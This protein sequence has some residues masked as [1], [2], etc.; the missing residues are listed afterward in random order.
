MPIMG[1]NCEVRV[2]VSFVAPWLAAQF[3][4]AH[5]PL[6]APIARSGADRRALPA[7]TDPA[8]RRKFRLYAFQF[9][10]R[11]GER[12]ATRFVLRHCLHY[13]GRIKTST[14]RQK[15]LT[16]LTMREWWKVVN[17]CNLAIILAA[18]IVQ[19]SSSSLSQFKGQGRWLIRE[20]KPVQSKC[21][22]HE[23]GVK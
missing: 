15:S 18:S 13:L 17:E 23:F 9:P 14:A 7:P 11:G 10:K 20:C 5:P 2:C 22:S 3:E 4:R 8:A 16:H 12:V 19:L 1:T 6:G 21:R